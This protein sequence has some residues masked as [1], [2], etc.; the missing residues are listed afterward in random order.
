MRK[1]FTM[2]RSTLRALIAGAATVAAL[3]G[4]SGGFGDLTGVSALAVPAASAADPADVSALAA[5]LASAA[6]PADA[7][8]LRLQFDT[9]GTSLDTATGAANLDG[10]GASFSRGALAAAGVT[11]GTILDVDR[12]KY[13][14]ADIAPGAADN[15]TT[16]DTPFAVPPID[17]ATDLGILATSTGGPARTTATVYYRDGSTTQEEIRVANWTTGNTLP[18]WNVRA[19]AMSYRNSLAGRVSNPGYLVSVPIHLAGGRDPAAMSLSTPSQGDIHVFAVGY[20]V[21]PRGEPQDPGEDPGGENPG[22]ENPGGENPGGENPGGENPGGQNPGGENP[23]GQNPGG[24]N[25][26]GENPGGENPGG[27]NPGG[28]N[29]GGGQP[30]DP[31]TGTPGT[32]TPGPRP[33]ASAPAVTAKVKAAADAVKVTLACAKPRACR[34][35]IALQAR[36]KPRGAKRAKTITLGRGAYTLKAGAGRAVTVKL[37]KQGRTELRRAG[38]LKA[39]IRVTVSGG[40]PVTRTVTLK[41]RR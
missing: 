11:A 23:G 24:E 32:G 4:I 6:D 15:L 26:G 10:S 28:Q 18:A 19:V 33:A 30:V 39:T 36:V 2:T 7:G 20:R 5:R 14:W 21:A 3:G 41:A 13:T 34:G 1:D 22:G 9:V 17:L 12:F 40:K 38:H 37:T 25:P 31:G 35:T 29:P 16:P 8:P 27:Q